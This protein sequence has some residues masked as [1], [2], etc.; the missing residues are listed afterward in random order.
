MISLELKKITFSHVSKMTRIAQLDAQLLDLELFN[1][2]QSYIQEIFTP[3][4]VS[5]R[6]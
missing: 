3:L 5:F 1:V 4:S 2:C 6:L